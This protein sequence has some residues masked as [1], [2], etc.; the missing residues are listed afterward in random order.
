MDDHV[1]EYVLDYARASLIPDFWEEFRIYKD[2]EKCP[3]YQA[4]KDLCEVLNMMLPYAQ[5]Y[6]EQQDVISPG[7]FLIDLMDEIYEQDYQEQ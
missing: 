2:M 6:D 1:Y 3:S 7:D 4:V 5:G